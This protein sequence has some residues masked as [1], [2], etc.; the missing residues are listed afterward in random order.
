MN[1]EKTQVLIQKWKD[2]E[3]DCNQI[4]SHLVRVNWLI[5]NFIISKHSDEMC[6]LFSILIFHQLLAGKESLL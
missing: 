2:E 3:S 4:K 1:I 6:N 5:L